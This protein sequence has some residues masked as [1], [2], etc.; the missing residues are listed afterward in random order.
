MSALAFWAL[1]AM[2]AEL[3][4]LEAASLAASS[5]A[6]SGTFIETAAMSATLMEQATA[7]ELATAAQ[8]NLDAAILGAADAASATAIEADAA[9]I[10]TATAL[11]ASVAAGSL[12]TVA[13]GVLLRQ[14]GGVVGR[15]LVGE[16]LAPAAPWLV[17]GGIGATVMLASQTAFAAS[18]GRV[19]G[20]PLPPPEAF[21]KVI[22]SRVSGLYVVR[23][24]ARPA[25][26]FPEGSPTKRTPYW[27]RRSTQPSSALT[28]PSS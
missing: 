9:A 13:Q 4:A 26:P 10:A 16:A 15:R 27:G 12:D 22:G 6:I 24:E 19:R 18:P 8:V 2:A 5:G 23:P 7:L 21:D 14:A 11:P 17:K 28:P 25:V 3:A 1:P 20:G